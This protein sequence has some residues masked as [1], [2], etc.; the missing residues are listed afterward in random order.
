M[1]DAL[2]ANEQ[3]ARSRLF[4]SELGLRP[5]EYGLVTL[6]RHANVDQPK[7]LAGLLEALG[8]ITAECPLVFPVHPRARQALDRCPTPDG[9][10]LLGP[11][12]YLDFIALDADARLVLTDSGGVQ[13]ET[14][15]LGVPCLTLRD[16]TERPITVTE[17]TNVVVGRNRDRIVG[18]ARKVLDEG[19]VPRRPA[20][21]DGKAGARIAQ[22]LVAGGGPEGHLRPTDLA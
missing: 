6:H 8:A 20:L 12:G 15:V 21:W 9:V 18:T 3:R 7:V 2:L 5:G 17:G 4:L 22:V 19:V 11:A 16:S 14:T 1:I 10:R 13:E